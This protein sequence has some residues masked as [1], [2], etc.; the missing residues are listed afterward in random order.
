MSFELPGGLIPCAP[1]GVGLSSR[2]FSYQQE[3]TPA[4]II[5]EN[6][7][8][9]SDAGFF[10]KWTH[11]L[12]HSLPSLFHRIQRF[13]F[14]TLFHERQAMEKIPRILGLFRHRLSNWS[15]VLAIDDC[16]VWSEYW[17]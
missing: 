2:L 4:E 13:C 10:I 14:I 11:F 3:C 1:L 9:I 5:P 12:R 17:K 7:T 6:R 8:L 15:L 16:D